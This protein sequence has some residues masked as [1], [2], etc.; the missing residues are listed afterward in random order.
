MANETKVVWGTPKTL[1]A[2][3]ASTANNTIS[4][5]DDASYG[6]V[7]DGLSY[8]DAEFVLS[9]AFATSPTENTTVDLLARELNIDSTNDAQAPETTYRAR[10]IGSFLLNNVTST[11]YLKL[12]AQDVPTEADYYVHNNGTGQ[13]MSAGWTLKV[14]PRSVGPA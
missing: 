7:A 11:Q 12:M 4:Q 6:I 1:E 8:P 13:T 3:G 9:C 14:T 2:N 10:Y 5:A